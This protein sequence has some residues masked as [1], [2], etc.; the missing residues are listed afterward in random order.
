MFCPLKHSRL[1]PIPAKDRNYQEQLGT[2][3]ALWKRDPAHASSA[4]LHIL[5][6]DRNVSACSGWCWRYQGN[7]PA[8]EPPEP[9]KE[10][11]TLQGDQ[12]CFFPY[13]SSPESHC[14]FIWQREKNS[15]IWNFWTKDQIYKSKVGKKKSNYFAC[16]HV[17][18]IVLSTVYINLYIIKYYICIHAL[19]L[20]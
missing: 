10:K 3:R 20:I 6:P 17:L 1:F 16:L 5:V 19:N 4:V 8:L 15:A 18:G 14:Q 11:D 7:C 2:V 12:K 9:R 13:P